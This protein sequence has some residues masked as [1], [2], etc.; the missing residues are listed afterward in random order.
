[1]SSHSIRH[2]DD[3][4]QVVVHDV[5]LDAQERR[6][7]ALAE[8]DNAKFGWFHIRA[9]IVSGIGFFTDA[10]DLFI[11]NL[12]V[13][14]LGYV[15][16]ADNKNVVPSSIDLGLK[17]SASIGTFIGQIFFGYLAD[18]LGRKKMYGIELMM[19]VVFTITSA[20]A[21]NA[22]RGITA[23]TMIMIWRFL[24]GIG[25]GGDYPL[26]AVITSEFATTK[27]R[28]AMI[29]A[30]F[31]MQGFGILSAAIVSTVTVVA[32]QNAINEDVMAFD[33]VWRICVGVGAIPGLVAIYF[34]LTIPET[35][36]YTMDINKDLSKA[37]KD[38]GN[39]L[40]LDA[41]AHGADAVAAAQAAEH[42][43][44]AVPKASWSDFRRHFSQWPNLK[45]LV[46]TSMTWF[47]LDVAFYGTGL[48]NA[49]ILT[50]M[51][52]VD[53]SSPYRDLYT[54]SVGNIIIAMLGTVPG[55][56]VTVFT[57]DRMGRKTI[58]LMGFTVLT[59]LF[60]IMGIGFNA[61]RDYSIVLFTVIFTLTQ[62][63]QNW[64]PNSTTFIVPGEVFPTRYRSTAHG[65]SAAMGKLGAIVAQVGFS[66]LKDIGGK[67][68]FVPE[69][70]IIFAVFMFIGLLFTFFI[71]ETAG[72]TLEELSGEDD[73]AARRTGA[74]DA[75]MQEV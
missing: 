54:A 59:V 41:K 53:K 32:F 23:T 74:D 27:R 40:N 9:C 2:V 24:L 19:I 56:W 4:S 65:I 46:G 16:F 5:A 13:Q 51:G 57:V 36:R 30:V 33:Y 50:A 52:Y 38:I 63:F 75:V 28:G 17:V 29:A 70:I 8:I 72:K 47:A 48:N 34:R 25:V 22:V 37:T 26:S 10:Y 69:L 64:G 61:I 43:A 15:Y 42:H 14:M 44:Q 68:E 62:F 67:G 60:L 3:S 49:I 12:V 55:Y 20:F 71:P 35:P 45:V 66:Q 18:R 1:M 39:V 31:A 6:R 73:Y 21:A 11:I 7:R 58:Q